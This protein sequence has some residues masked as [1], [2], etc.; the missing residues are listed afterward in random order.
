MDLSPVLHE[1]LRS[2]SLRPA[3]AGPA[4]GVASGL[5]ARRGNSS[6]VDPSTLSMRLSASSLAE[7]SALVARQ[8]SAST[9]ATVR[10]GSPPRARDSSPGVSPTG[11]DAG[12]LP[13]INERRAPSAGKGLTPRNS[14]DGNKVG[15]RRAMSHIR[16]QQALH[17]HAYPAG[18][19]RHTCG[20][21]CAVYDLPTLPWSR[22][23]R[24]QTPPLPPPLLCAR[25]V[26]GASRAPAPREPPPPAPGH[27][28]PSCR[29]SEIAPSRYVICSPK[30]ICSSKQRCRSI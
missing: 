7:A 20:D 27:A 6:A 12:R 1:A 22:P 10:N 14:I 21:R 29:P 17:R 9:L 25:R 26:C 24:S 30:Q 4:P 3:G 18:S 13:L 15:R 8:R 23:A 11:L 28:R 2:A 19:W 16:A 5:R